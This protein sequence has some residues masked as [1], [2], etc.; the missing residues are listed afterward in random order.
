MSFASSKTG[1]RA[2][3]TL[4]AHGVDQAKELRDHF[5]SLPAHVRPELIIS[6]PF[7]R[8]I[9]TITIVA[10]ALDLPIHINPNIGEWFGRTS[11]GGINPCPASAKVL[12]KYFPRVMVEDP[13]TPES[14]VPLSGETM[15]ELHSRTRRALQEII[16]CSQFQG[17]KTVLLCT[18]AAT[19]ISCGRTLTGDTLLD[20]HTGTAS[21]G[22]YTR[23]QN[24]YW[25]CVRNGDCSFLKLGEERN[26]GFSNIDE[27]G[28]DGG[29]E[30]APKL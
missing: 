6:S 10:D 20:V 24:G 4:A 29:I 2:D 5:L 3:P 30:N 26:W 7:Y 21:L 23:E 16:S 13:S 28:E 9:E 19:N 25:T 17:Y 8:C 11:R 15:A 1:I 22:E 27:P 18:H 12:Q 14:I